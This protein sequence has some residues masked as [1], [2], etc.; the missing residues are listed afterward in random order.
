MVNQ[1][2]NPYVAGAPLRGEQGFFGRQDTLEWVARE[3]RNPATNA[4]VLFGQRRIGKTTI[5]LQLERTLPA[6]VFLPVYFDL[7]D[8]ATRPL[9]RVLADLAD[10]VAE[11]IGLEPP[12]PADFDDKGHFFRREFL[13][14]LYQTL[15]ETRRPVL[16][17]DEFDVLDQA[18]EAELPDTVAAK[19]L[20]PFLRRTMT[21][22]PRL[23]FVF[24]VGRRAED[25]SLDFTATFK[26]SLVREIW[27]LDRKS[28]EA[29]IRQ[30]EVNGTLRF[31]DRAV[32]RILSLTCCHPYLTQLLC[33]RIWERA[34]AGGS[35]GGIKPCPTIDAP[36]V[37]AA[38]PDALEAGNQALV[39]LW[40]GLSPAEKIYAAALAETAEEG[41]TIPEDQVIQVLSTHAARLRTREVELAPRDLVKRRVLEEAGERKYRF[42]VELFRRWVRQHKPLRDVKDELDRIEPVADRLYGIGMD[43]LRRRQW[44][45]AVRYFQD[46]LAAYPGHFRARL[47]LGEA[48]LELNQ[49][50]GAVAE[51]ERAYELDRDE[52]RLTL[53]RAL[54][55]Q[56]R[57]REAAGDEEG[58]LAACERALQISPSERAAQEM[59][60]AIW[61]RRGDAALERGDLEKALAAY[62]EAGDTERVAYV[63]ALQRRQALA[64][65]EAEARAYERAREWAEAIAVYEQLLSQAP[66][67][68]SRAAWQAAMERC[69]EEEELARLFAEGVGAMKQKDWKRAQRAFADVVYR[70]PD[71]RRDGQRVSELLDEAIEAERVR[72]LPLLPRILARIANEKTLLLLESGVL[73]SLAVVVIVT[74]MQQRIARAPL[75]G[76]VAPLVVTV[77][78]FLWPTSTLRSEI[79]MTSVPPPTI[80]PSTHDLIAFVSDRDGS[81]EIYIMKRDGSGVVRLTYNSFYDYEPAWS[82]N[83]QYI[84]FVSYREGNYE[85][86]VMNAD[87]SAITRLL[88]SLPG[89]RDPVWSPD[90]QRIA[91]TSLRDG[92]HEIYVMNV[93]G[94]NL[95]RL[96]RHPADD[97]V[98]AWSPDGQRIAFTSFRDGNG[99][100]Y[101]MNADGSGITNLTNHQ[102][103][104]GGPAWSPDGQRIAFVSDRD[105]NY[106]IYLMNADGSG[107]I[108]L[109]NHPGG[110]YNPAW[111]PDGQRIAFV[112][113]RDGNDEIYVMNADG[114]GVTNLT[115]N[116]A[117]DDYPAWSP[118]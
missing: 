16:L 63:E 12:D 114:S 31:T 87:G 110:D 22:D 88:N 100:V 55:A 104:D 84:A 79:A 67:E 112:S 9:G 4:L 13:P 27:V 40:D 75:A 54:I 116:P 70:R 78:P 24:V 1:P 10:A 37:E 57:A 92:N 21:E 101:V 58:A 25:L 33:Q 107:V 85:I 90:N 36:E 34:Y 26:A 8:Q 28:A 69:R 23:A 95:I 68:E 32:E 30:A 77:P 49:A 64:A 65:M 2:A 48:L 96:T 18:A 47:H 93:D 102:A 17:L 113:N 66:D 45:Q 52:A 44:G 72:A 97:G 73:I 61:R 60:A 29:L 53:A 89:D 118:R 80:L 38:V 35:G 15:G 106:E 6:D 98:P 83:G 19:A 105:G 103:N 81:A 86:Y 91:F 115:K 14:R 108:N 51:L 20:F 41:E 99:E 43:F 117:R 111:S 71:Y 46:A 109:T 82:P 76:T 42:A 56:A 50:D 39:W 7:Q 62:R 94:S 5:L 3:L 59:R 11:R 74:A